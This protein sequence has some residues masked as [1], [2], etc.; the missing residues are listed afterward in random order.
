[1]ELN[2]MKKKRGWFNYLADSIIGVLL[3]V[4]V[5]AIINGVAGNNAK[6][7]V[8][9]VV[10]TSPL[11]DYSGD[12]A[13]SSIK[14]EKPGGSESTYTD[15]D[16]EY[17]NETEVGISQQD[18][19]DGVEHD[20]NKSDN[21]KSNIN[22]PDKNQS[23]N[24]NQDSTDAVTTEPVEQNWQTGHSISEEEKSDIPLSEKEDDGQEIEI[25]FDEFR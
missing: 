2:I 16:S 5:V 17:A 7:S 18:T 20:S 11:T 12:N 19:D 9:N 6:S 4:S 23:N 21:V 25:S 8:D 24:A 10:V 22:G 1:M 14:D 13:P 3:I 15:V